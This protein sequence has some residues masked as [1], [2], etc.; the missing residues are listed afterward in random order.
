MIVDADTPDF[1]EVLQEALRWLPRQVAND[2]RVGFNV[3]Y[4]LLLFL[5][6]VLKVVQVTVRV[7][8]LHEL[9]DQPL[10]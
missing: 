1:H 3:G 5:E 7:R 9:L 2:E 4:Q 8:L 10:L 6:D